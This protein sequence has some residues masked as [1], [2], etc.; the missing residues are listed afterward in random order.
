M[1]SG[2]HILWQSKSLSNKFINP[3][4]GLMVTYA[5]KYHVFV[6]AKNRWKSSLAMVST[7]N[8]LIQSIC[9]IVE[10]TEDLESDI[11]NACVTKM[12]KKKTTMTTIESEKWL[13]CLVLRST[14]QVLEPSSI[15][16]L[17]LQY[18]SPAPAFSI[19]LYH[20]LIHHLLINSF[21][22]CQ[23]TFSENK[24]WLATK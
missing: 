8:T 4:G 7:I 17:F 12:F 10:F 2:S 9:K 13:S 18:V 11:R 6:S 15:L 21:I 23:G 22:H 1:N 3:R 14:T 24:T 16:L 5:F 19:F 20:S